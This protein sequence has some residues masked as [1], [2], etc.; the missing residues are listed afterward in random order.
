M[1]IINTK[2]PSKFIKLNATERKKAKSPKP[3]SH[4]NL[5]VNVGDRFIDVK[6]FDGFLDKL[7]GIFHIECWGDY[8]KNRR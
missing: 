4:C 1:S 5:D 6:Y 8:S 7:F 3:C 2:T